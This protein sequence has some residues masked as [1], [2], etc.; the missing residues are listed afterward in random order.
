[1]NILMEL[2][3][4]ILHLRGGWRRY[5]V[6]IA[7]V[8]VAVLAG[9]VLLGSVQSRFPYVTL[10][11]AVVIVALY[12]GLFVGLLA[13]ALSALLASYHWIE[14]AGGPLAQGPA[15]WQG[16]G[17]FVA[18]CVMICV[19]CELMHRAQE[20]AR[21]AVAAERDQ[22]RVGLRLS[23]ALEQAGAG[24]WLL[25][26]ATY[27]MQE[28]ALCARLLG[29]PAATPTEFSTF[30]E[31]RARIDPRDRSGVDEK[32][33][34]AFEGDG[35]LD[36]EFR[37]QWPDATQHWLSVRGQVA[38]DASGTPLQI[39]GI[40][41]DITGLKRAEESLLSVKIGDARARVEAVR[42]SQAKDRFLATLS[43]ELRN[44]LAPVLAT[45][46]LLQ[47]D[48][49][50]DADTQDSLGVIRRNCEVEARL[51]DD[52]LDVTRIVRGKVELSHHPVDLSTIIEHAVEVCRP[53]IDARKLEFGVDLTGRPY[54][55]NADAGRMQQVFWNLIKNAVKFTPAG[56]CVGIACRRASEG[57]AVIVEITDSGVGIQPAALPSI[58]NAFEQGGAETT[59]HFGG[60]GLGL[61]ICKAIVELHGGSITAQS[62]GT[63]KGAK[64]TVRLPL[65]VAG[66]DVVEKAAA[67]TKRDQIIHPLRILLVEDHGDTARIMRR[68]LMGDGHQVKTAGDVA[69]ALQMINQCE[70]DL[71]LSDLGLPDGSGLDLMRTLRQRGKTLPGIALS[72]YGQ[73]QD[74]NQSRAAGFAKHLTKPVNLVQLEEAI[75][76][77]N[78]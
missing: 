58:F 7:A 20:R 33:R 34:L 18:S 42:A 54:V 76:A 38:R 22:L 73:E 75:A 51:I 23:Q 39:A 70:F 28:N 15:D 26:L 25:D 72:G 50:L 13:T 57:G 46:C 59:R 77:V 52:L 29:G 17:I 49:D 74:V 16:M 19:V 71:L 21:T 43:H 53:D 24:L 11:P 61:T 44:P 62:Q 10:Y 40:K 36:W 64:F 65:L 41:F 63:G 67:A 48:A 9:H 60:L 2:W 47:Q 66:Q 69:T 78:A 12:G 14:P 3:I 55:V 56:G 8:A 4:K 5:F 6:A 31:L 30:A 32:L 35:V 68:L 45:V 1:M 27:R 37:V